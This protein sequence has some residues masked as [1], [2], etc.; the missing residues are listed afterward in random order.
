MT[1][2]WSRME[3]RFGASYAESYARDMVLAPLGGRT[4][5]EAL[6]DQTLIAESAL[7]RAQCLWFTTLVSKASSLPAI[8]K[9]LKQ[10][11]VE[12]HRTIEMAQGQKTSRIVA[13]TFFTERQRQAWRN[14]RR[15]ETQHC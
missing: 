9:A 5:R 14:Q 1:D 4:V 15:G 11:G 10:A 13:W 12:Q 8:N 3:R 6:D 2:F 7:V